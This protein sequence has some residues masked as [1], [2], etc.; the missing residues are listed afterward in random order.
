M[1][2]RLARER[3]DVLVIGGGITG[4]GIARDAALRGLRTA[5]VEASDFGSGTSSRS[6]RL[7]HG[8]LRY[9]EHGHLRLVFESSR[10]RRILLG[11]A[12]HLVRPLRFVW[13]VY[14]GS[15]V[16]LLRL[17]AG[18]TLYDALALFRNV[19]RHRRLEPAELMAME[20]GL[21]CEGLR[22]GALYY[23]ARTDD[24]R[25]TLA[26]VID[27]V[28]AGCCALNYARVDALLAD[29]KRAAGASVS[30]LVSANTLEVRSRAIVNATGPWSDRIR[31][32]EA[33]IMGSGVSGTKGTHVALPRNR[34]GNSGALALLHPRDG[35]VFF[36]LPAGHLTLVTTTETP[37]P[38]SPHIVRASESDVAYLLQGANHYFPHAEL[39]RTDVLSAWAGLR[40]LAA[41]YV[42][43]S[44][45]AASREHHLEFGPLGVL[46]V[47]GGKLTTFRSMAAEVVDAIVV[48]LGNLAQ[49]PSSTATRPLPGGELPYDD[50]VAA[51]RAAIADTAVAEHLAGAYGTR[52]RDVADL[53]ARD[54]ALAERLVE[55]LP[56]LAAECIYAVTNELAV[57]LGDILIRRTHVA[58]ETPDHGTSVAPRV[59]HLVGSLF[60]WSERQRHLALE[61]YA[62]E[63]AAMFEV[64]PD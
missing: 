47:T 5:L 29:G 4:A 59:A 12:P 34:V 28:A 53:A 62:A 43:G 57:T 20:P 6:S 63:V 18:L 38:P 61:S 36:V 54:N 31:R 26:N 8:G 41:S 64:E 23:D 35:R 39:Q 32:L 24:S 37:G 56:Y 14:R 58:F 46:H 15:R 22:G 27:A 1:A 48:R 50:T 52:W 33:A 30:D 40:P 9:L 7:V 21:R 44:T 51:A 45:G 49:L 60:G 17:L 25:L 19:G 3:F 55:G 13:P 11:I 16:S 10:E 2:H 42:R